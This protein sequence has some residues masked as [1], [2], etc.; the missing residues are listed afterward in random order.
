MPTNEISATIETFLSRIDTYLQ[1]L[2]IT[3]T[4]FVTNDEKNQRSKYEPAEKDPPERRLHEFGQFHIHP[5]QAAE[6]NE[7]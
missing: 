7:W 3:V 4:R 5:H 2:I 6:R 1:F